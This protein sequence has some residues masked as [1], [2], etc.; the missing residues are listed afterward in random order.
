MLMS[1]LAFASQPRIAM[2][3]GANPPWDELHVFDAVVVEPLHVPDPK[4]HADARTELFAYVALGEVSPERGYLKAIPAAWKLGQNSVWGSVVLDQAQAAWPAFFAE[5]VIKPLWDAGYRGFFLD[6]LDSYQLYTKT[7]TERAKQEAG[8]VA[9]IRE[10]K[11]RYPQAKLIFNRGFEILPQ[12]HQEVF[13]VAAESLFQR[14]DAAQ[15]K[16]VV[17]PPN[18][19]EWLLGQLNR[20]H[21][22]YDLPV[23][24]IDYV[25]PAKRDLARATAANIRDLGFIPW[26]TNPELDMLGVGEVEVMPRKVLMVHNTANT[27]YD[28]NNTSVLH[29][30]TMPLN[31]L[32][33][34][35]EYLDARRPLPSE[36]L[37][38]RYAG[39]VV[40]LDQPAGREGAALTVWLKRQMKA[41]VPIVILGEGGFLFKSADAAHFGLH[42]SISRNERMRLHVAHRDALVG[43]EAQP[44]FDRS[45]FFPLRAQGAEVLLTLAN[46]LN[47]TR[48]VIALTA[49][50]GYALNP[51][52]LI[53]LPSVLGNGKTGDT[54]RNM[55]WVINPI[56]FLRRALKLPDMPVPD[57]TTESGRRKLMVH[58][59]GDGFASRGEFPG[60][61]Y[62]AEVLLNQVLKKYPVPMTMSVIQGEIAPNGLYPAQSAALEDIARAMFALPQ[63]EIASHSL[64]HP[65]QWRK[66][67]ANP[68]AEGYHLSLKNYEFD[69]QQEI[70]GSISYIETKLAPPGK[71][72]K[73]FLWTGDCNVGSDALEIAAREGVASMNGGET[74]IT[75]SYPTL[76]LVAPL[77]VPKDGQFQVYAPNQ[78][79]NV[80]TNNWLGPYYGYERVIETFEMTEAPY[81]LKPVDIYFHTYSASKPASLK[82]L[83]RVFKWAL[84][85]PVTPVHVS[86][87]TRQVRDFNR[88]VVARTR[89]GWLVHGDGSLRE[90][91]APLSLGQP[92]IGAGSSVVGFNRHEDQQYLHLGDSEANIRFGS[93]TTVSPYLVSANARIVHAA[94]TRTE[95]GETF[96]LALSG[97]VP[98]KFDLSLGSRCVVSADGRTI[99]ADSTSNGVSHFSMRD[100][101]IDELRIHCPR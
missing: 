18:D 46:E 89:D 1:A 78:N 36:Q 49:W 2:F 37:T 10:L 96:K 27:E 75:R 60:A 63:V 88:M 81:R 55:R 32:G 94:S 93:A 66:A 25:P 38:G 87:Y 29:Y 97:H 54:S 50:G 6:T 70:A 99:R 76:T 71:K 22:E 52:V 51:H 86:E 13:A 92:V 34:S 28:L 91:R 101:V 77:G 11:K 58:M 95:E 56:E 80:Y 7:A 15:Q 21:Q 64:S 53:E 48:D 9:V 26:V 69:L 33:Y 20:I 74:I 16:Y 45:A 31:Y 67:V 90:L 44:A 17:V 68:E 40:W 8:M 84:A 98:L 3:Y 23:L 47:E 19:R 12:V 72:V 62:G 4:L 57:V 14:W 73:V 5:R 82:A 79:E 35:A 85:Q 41:G 61:P 65:F 100:H 43:F 83:D 30:A 39:I 24:S 42:D 59:D